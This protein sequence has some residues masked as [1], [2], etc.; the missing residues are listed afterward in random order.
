MVIN[1]LHLDIMIRMMDPNLNAPV[2]SSNYPSEPSFRIDAAIKQ[3]YQ[4]GYITARQ[5]KVDSSWIAVSI[6]PEG[7]TLLEEAG[8][9]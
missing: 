3:L 8:L 7:H 6:T 1:P 9:V 5:S 2:Q 4:M